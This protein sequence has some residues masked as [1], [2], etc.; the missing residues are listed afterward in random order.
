[1]RNVEEILTEKGF[2]PGRMISW[3]KSGYVRN[4][5][6]NEVVFNAR[7]CVLGEGNI[8]WGDLDITKDRELLSSVATEAG[9]KLYIL[10]EM[11]AWN[12]DISDHEILKR[13]ISIIE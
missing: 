5:P 1:M 8:W 10:R 13:A 7:I 12:E 2:I 4:N 9:K 3:S 11:D 6:G